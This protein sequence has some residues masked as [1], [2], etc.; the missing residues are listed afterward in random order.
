[1]EH[2]D[3]KPILGQIQADARQAADTLLS[4]ARDRAAAIS[5]RSN[6][7]V[8]EMV[9][10]TRA[11]ALAEADLLEDRMLRLAG[12]EQ[13][14]LLVTAKRELIGRAFEQAIQTLNKAPKDQVTR[15]MGNLLVR[16]ASGNETLIAGEINDAF[17]TQ[18][19]I[20]DINLRLSQSGRQGNLNAGEGREPGVCGVVLRGR[21]SRVN[22]T[23]AALMETRREEMESAVAGI[24]F[25]PPQE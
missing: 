13:R 6:L 1:M 15:V 12:L 22:C 11:K 9:E 14:N 7:R 23:F 8:Q 3:T 17:F 19:F 4:E 10:D 20:R 18:D 16:Y 2:L 5:E 21:N 25:P 24:L